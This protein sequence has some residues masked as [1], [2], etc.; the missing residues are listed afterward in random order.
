MRQADVGT[1]QSQHQATLARA[2]Q[3]RADICPLFR[4]LRTAR[5]LKNARGLSKTW[6]RDAGAHRTKPASTASTLHQII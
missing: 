4:A 5:T 1:G 2:G 6:D 3:N